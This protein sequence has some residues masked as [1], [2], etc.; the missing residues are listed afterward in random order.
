MGCNLSCIYCYEHD[1][2]NKK[3]FD[4][5]STINKLT[6]FLSTKTPKGSIIKLLG[7][8]PFIVFSDIKQLCEVMWSKNLEEN[9]LFH[10]TSN[11]T[12]VHGKIKE[13]L[14]QNKYRFTVKLSL[15][16]N[17]EAHEINRPNSF[18]KIDIDFFRDTWPE[19]GVKMVVSPATIHL[20]AESI[21]FLHEKGFKAIKPN[22]AELVD[23]N[24][25][26]LHEL[27]YQQ[28]M[29]LV[30]YYLDNPELKPCKFLSVPLH[31]ITNDT[32]IFH[33]CTL[34]EREIIDYNTGK[35]YPCMFFLPSICGGKKSEHLMNL[36]MTDKKNLTSLQC[37][38]CPFD[39]VCLTC[40]AANYMQRGHTA[41]RDMKICEFQKITFLATAK[42][43]F[44]KYVVKNVPIPNTQE[45]AYI[46]KDIAAI[47]RYKE[48]FHVIESKYK[49]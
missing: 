42:L 11:G 36:D 37:S 30:D 47:K 33:R 31:R 45:G 34:G 10:A 43:L 4:V 20:F 16:G 29:S 2:N 22:F 5:E 40:Y 1:K 7:G 9:Y 46:Y 3:T 8:E 48:S 18:D 41:L 12:F 19:I 49:K 6:S 13:W 15:D 32:T 44:K 14:Y 17:R 25:D 39:N 24:K 28:M 26:G 23:W 38:T 27:F 21:I 35:T